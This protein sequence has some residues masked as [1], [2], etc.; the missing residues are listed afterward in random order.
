MFAALACASQTWRRRLIHKFERKQ[1]EELKAE[2][3][4]AFRQQTAL[5]SSPAS[6]IHFSSKNKT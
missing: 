3:H 2:L 4:T 6:R 1:I 5:V